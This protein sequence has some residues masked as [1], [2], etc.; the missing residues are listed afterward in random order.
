MKKVRFV[1]LLFP[2]EAFSA[3]SD[4]SYTL[5]II[6]YAG[7]SPAGVRMVMIQ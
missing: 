1:I 2:F 6:G 4:W 5:F 7:G 3:I